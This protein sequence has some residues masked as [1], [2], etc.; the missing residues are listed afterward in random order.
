MIGKLLL[1]VAF[2][3]SSLVV[4][5]HFY[6]RDHAA[7]NEDSIAR[8]IGGDGRCRDDGPWRCGEVV[9]E[10]RKK[11]CWRAEDGSREGCV[12]FF[13]YALSLPSRLQ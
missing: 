13:D 11:N 3:F 8:S 10:R 4:A 1:V 6:I 12:K 5:W 7:L 2:A 9:V